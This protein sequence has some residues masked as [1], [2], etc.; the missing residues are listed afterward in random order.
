MSGKPDGLVFFRRAFPSA[1][2]VLL[3]GERPALVDTGFGGDFPRTERLLREAGTP[4]GNI[5]LILN[6]HS[7][8]DHSGGNHALQGLHGTP[9]A[10][11]RWESG[12]V[13]RREPEAC[14]ARWLGQPV[15]AYQVEHSL[16]D[17]DEIEAGDTVLR[18]VHTPGHTLGHVSLYLPEKQALIGGDVFHA[19]DVAWLNPFREGPAAIDRI[20]ESLDRL[21]ELPVQWACSGHGPAIEDPVFAMDAARRRYEKWLEEPE[22]AAWHACKR[23]FAY[24]LMLEDGMSKEKSTAY[25]LDSPWF[26]D[27]ARYSFGLAPEEF[28]EPLIEETLRSGAG[29]WRDGRLR[30]ASPYAPP[31]EGWPSGPARP[32]RWPPAFT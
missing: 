19:D 25:L 4:P 21:A 12:L 9:I 24:A 5:S 29:E 7:H 1:N 20:I 11:H 27:Y 22:K 18:V 10:A 32:E 2:M 30:A 15:E 17:G 8:C 14:A 23:I 13:N 16:S 26:S 6:T 28:V 31:P 3:T